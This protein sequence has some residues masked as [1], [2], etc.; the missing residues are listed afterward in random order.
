MTFIQY[1]DETGELDITFTSGKTYRYRHVPLD[2]YDGLLEAPSKG[3]FF[4][5]NIKDAF[6]VSEVVRRSNL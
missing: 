2:I 6:A 3:T 1:D 4:N 5:N